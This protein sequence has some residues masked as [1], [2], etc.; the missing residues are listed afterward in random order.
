M[1]GPAGG[2]DVAAGL[3]ARLRAAG[4]VFAEDEARLL[5]AA[6]T[7][8][9]ELATLVERRVAGTPLEQ[10]LGWVEFCG[11]RVAV[12]PGVFVPRRRTELL[13]VVVARLLRS[14]GVVGSAAPAPVVEMCCGAAAVGAALLVDPGGIDLHAVDIDPAAVAWARRNVA[15]PEHVYLG[16]LFAPLPARLKGAVAVVVA[17][18][19]YVPTKAIALMPPEARLFEPAVALDGGSD[20]LDVQRR[21]IDEAPDW[22]APGAHLVIETSLRQSAGTAAAMAGRGFT[23]RV[24]R[25]DDLDGTAVVGTWSAGVG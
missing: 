13:A 14:V 23:T 15:V 3:V 8:P 5:M 25:D 18:A 22:L 1:S 24:V 9:G 17:N 6:A 7:A 19:P 10:V 16:D 11:L 21:V 20:G 2:P 12:G 4:C